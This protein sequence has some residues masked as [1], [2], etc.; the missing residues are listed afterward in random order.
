MIDQV[1]LLSMSADAQQVKRVG[2]GESADRS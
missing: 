1:V 2:E